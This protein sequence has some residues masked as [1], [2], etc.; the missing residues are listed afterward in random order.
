MK[1]TRNLSG[2]IPPTGIA[3]CLI[4]LL[5]L[6]MAN[7]SPGRGDSI[8][9][10]NRDG[11]SAQAPIADIN[12]DQLVPFNLDSDLVFAMASTPIAGDNNITERA[13]LPEDNQRTIIAGMQPRRL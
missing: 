7:A 8:S 12:V 13:V 1:L 6:T 3:L 4:F 10:S 2:W 9:L 5:T 11:T